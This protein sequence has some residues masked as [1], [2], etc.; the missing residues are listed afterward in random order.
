MYRDGPGVGR[1]GRRHRGGRTCHGVP[2][3]EI[4]AYADRIDAS[5]IVVGEHGEHAE[6]FGGVGRAVADRAD[7]EVVVVSAAENEA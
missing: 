7:R 4:L 1:R 5:V 6:H 2:P 3:D